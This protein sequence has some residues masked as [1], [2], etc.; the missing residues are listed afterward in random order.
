MKKNILSILFVLTGFVMHAQ[1]I[2]EIEVR[3]VMKSNPSFLKNLLEIREGQALDTTRIKADVEQL[4][5]LPGVA[6]ATYSVEAQEGGDYKVVFDITENFT[7]IPAANVYTT[8]DGE[9]AFRLGLY[10]FNAFG[11]NIAFGGF[12]QRDIYN[13]YGIQFRAPQLFNREWG[14]AVNFLDWTTQEPVFFDIGTADYKYNN[15]SIEAL[16]LHTF[17]PYNRIEF[18]LTIFKET[19]DYKEGVFD[20]QVVPLNVEADKWA[21]KGLYEYNKVESSYQY[22]E[23]VK[24]ILNL[25]YNR[26]TEDALPSFWIG[27]NDFIYYKRVGE[28][29]NWANRI[30]VGLAENSDSPFAPFSVDNNL[31]I[32][33]VG[34][35]IDRGTGAIV[36]NT[37]Y[38][39]TLWEKSWFVLQGN[40]FIDAGSWRQ[41]GGELDDF[42]ESENV[43][44]YPGIG[45]RA[46]HKKIFGAV[47]RIDYGYGITKNATNGLVFGIRQYF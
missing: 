35:T 23:G 10:E 38:R 14:L 4:N 32:R 3:N 18:G 9:F 47:F 31:N 13:S 20:E 8:N 24:N 15:F 41:P 26:S 19:Y 44:V 11:R 30:R 2:G 28:R 12:F 21:I 36:I 7:I 22:F 33:G 27:W 25:Q 45:L 39:H 34:N 1:K 5:R 46:I 40:A 6:N 43:R 29:G 42:V 16:G 37:E 17:N